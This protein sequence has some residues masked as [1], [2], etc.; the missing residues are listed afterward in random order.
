M[1]VARQALLS[2]EFSIRQNTGWIDISYFRRS[3]PRIKPVSP[4][5]QEDSYHWATK[6]ALISRVHIFSVTYQANVDLD[7]SGWGSVTTLSFPFPTILWRKSLCEHIGESSPTSLKVDY[8]HKVKFS[9]QGIYISSFIYLFTDLFM[10]T[11]WLT[12]SVLTRV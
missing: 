7:R 4:T 6:E 9:M 5:L 12:G 1:T 10:L 8:P 2:M 3:Q 11:S